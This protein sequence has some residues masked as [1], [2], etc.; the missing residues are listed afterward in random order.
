MKIRPD[1]INPEKNHTEKLL[2]WT[3]KNYQS[4]RQYVQ[5]GEEDSKLQVIFKGILSI[6]GLLVMVLLSPFLIV[7]LMIA[8]AAVF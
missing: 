8:F 1:E 3:G 6:F 2:D 7:G 5:V 4:F